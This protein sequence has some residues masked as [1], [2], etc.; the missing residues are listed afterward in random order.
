M[1]WEFLV[2]LFTVVIANAAQSYFTTWRITSGSFLQ[3]LFRQDNPLK[4]LSKNSDITVDELA[5]I[6]SRIELV[7]QYISKMPIPQDQL[8]HK[9]GEFISQ[10]FDARSAEDE[11]RSREVT[12]LAAKLEAFGRVIIKGK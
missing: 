5:S 12:E 1:A 6:K 9:V 2:I 11:R 7:E 3:G 10:K 4:Q 8:I